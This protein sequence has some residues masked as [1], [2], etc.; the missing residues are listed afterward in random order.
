MPMQYDPKTGIPSFNPFEAELTEGVTPAPLPVA[1][2]TGKLDPNATATGYFNKTDPFR[3][4]P[5][6]GEADV[7]IGELTGTFRRVGNKV[8]YNV[9]GLPKAEVPPEPGKGKGKGKGEDYVKINRPLRFKTTPPIPTIEHMAD[10]MLA[11]AMRRAKP[12]QVIPISQEQLDRLAKDA[13]AAHLDAN[14]ATDE[15]VA[16][17]EKQAEARSIDNWPLLRRLIK[18]LRR[19]EDK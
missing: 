12:G 18:R 14:Y 17:I 2:A 9:S 8:T 6:I 1:T 19:S 4:D 3:G 13:K 15:E 7:E 5:P 10:E 16:E 11:E